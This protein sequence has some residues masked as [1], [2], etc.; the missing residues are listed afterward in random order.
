MVCLDFAGDRTAGGAFDDVGIK[1]P[2]GKQFDI[3]GHLPELFDK[4]CSDDAALLL[5]IRD[6]L[7]RAK[8]DFTGINLLNG[9]ANFTEEHLHLG[10]FIQAHETRVD[11]NAAHFHSCAMQQHGQNGAVHAAGDT[12]DDFAI[13]HLCLDAFDHL[14]LEGIDVEPG[15]RGT[16][17]G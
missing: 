6:A 10:S 3:V 1:G 9:H 8:E 11:K 2:L 17:F 4:E 5:G 13:T 12:T 7:E 15:E 14:R 16:T